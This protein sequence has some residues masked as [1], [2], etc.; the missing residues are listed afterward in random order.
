MIQDDA[1]LDKVSGITVD[2]SGNLYTCSRE[3]SS[4]DQWS[5]QSGSFIATFASGFSDTPEQIV[6][7]YSGFSG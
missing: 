4:V 5:A 3:P 2:S 6:P 7:V 1:R